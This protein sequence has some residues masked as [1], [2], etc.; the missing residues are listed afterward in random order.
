M[1]ICTV[2]L[3]QGVVVVLVPGAMALTTAGRRPAAF[4]TNMSPLYQVADALAQVV[5]H[6]TSGHDLSVTGVGSSFV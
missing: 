3:C 2:A 6:S 4:W 1:G 5:E